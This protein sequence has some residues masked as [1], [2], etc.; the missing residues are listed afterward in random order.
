MAQ[1]FSI[2]GQK[3]NSRRVSYIRERPNSILEIVY[4]TKDSMALIDLSS[5]D[6][7]PNSA[8]EIAAFFE[9]QLYTDFVNV[10][11]YWVNPERVQ[12]IVPAHD[13]FVIDF[14]SGISI[15]T[16]N[17]TAISNLDERVN[18]VV[19]AGS[20]S[21]DTMSFAYP[22]TTGGNAADR[23]AV[24]DATKLYSGTIPSGVAFTSNEI[25][26][27]KSGVWLVNLGL[28]YSSATANSIPRA[29]IL[30]DDQDNIGLLKPA[31]T[32]ASVPV[33]ET[34]A[35]L[36]NATPTTKF[37][38]I[39]GDNGPASSAFVVRLSLS[40]L[41]KE[42]AALLNPAGQLTIGGVAVTINGQPLVI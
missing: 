3:I 23:T 6:S 2:L 32:T 15:K 19:T 8:A 21:F 36:T 24:F 42:A 26:G 39:Y 33:S 13:Y 41:S 18:G 35:F 22:D 10:D 12:A 5:I 38:V 29:K 4:D 1:Y 7:D 37:K 14:G 31:F 16:R 17:T 9:N 25:S 20:A 11:A 34:L 40:M 27:L 30:I 28:K